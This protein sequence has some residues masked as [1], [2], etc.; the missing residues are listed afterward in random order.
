MHPCPLASMG[1]SRPDKDYQ[2]G[3]LKE[4]EVPTGWLRTLPSSQSR[5]FI[6]LWC[7]SPP[8]SLWALISLHCRHLAA[9]V[10]SLPA[11]DTSADR[12]RSPS[13]S[14]SLLGSTDFCTRMTGIDESGKPD[15]CHDTQPEHTKILQASCL[16]YSAWAVACRTCA[17]RALKFS[18]SWDYPGTIGTA[19]SAGFS[20]QDQPWKVSGREQ[21]LAARQH[22]RP[23]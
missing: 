8:K 18:P 6:K 21:V 1:H 5:N 19:G 3:L 20:N 9:Q 12:S 15:I 16:M 17:F 22:Q 23:S 10:S 2:S 7:K 11:C 4:T 14:S 13:S